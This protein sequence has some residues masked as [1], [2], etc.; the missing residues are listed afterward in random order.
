MVTSVLQNPVLVLN[1]NWVAYR[2]AT[3]W[4]ALQKAA[5]G[6]VAIIGDDFRAYELPDWIE[7]WGDAAKACKDAE[8][9]AIRCGGCHVP[10]PEV[11]QAK[12]YSGF[13]AKV[14]F[15]RRNVFKRDDDTCQY[16]GRRLKRCDLTLDHVVPR[17]RGGKTTW[18]NVVLAC[19]P[20]NHRKD[21]R[22]TWEAGMKLRREPKRPHWA[23]LS[24]GTRMA[25]PAS[26]EKFLGEL[27]WNLALREV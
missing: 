1:A 2:T 17:C 21:N 16:C 25:A 18:E 22:L 10:V 13:H 19:V 11:V 26:W 12:G 15:S 7:T 8:R 24:E 3:V 4:W 5:A 6:R 23:E 14:V 20:C 27:Y 9:A